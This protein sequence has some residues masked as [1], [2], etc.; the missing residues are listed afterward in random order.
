MHGLAS[1]SAA[2]KR[3]IELLAEAG[4]DQPEV[5]AQQ[6][7][8]QLSGGLRQRALIAAALAGDPELLVADEPTS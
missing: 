8:S 5:R 7:P 4:V 3:A 6:L 2:P 1:R